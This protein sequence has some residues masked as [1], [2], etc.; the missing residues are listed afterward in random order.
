[1][2]GTGLQSTADNSDRE[3]D[4]ERLATADGVAGPADKDAAKETAGTEQT[5]HGALNGLG[6][7][8]AVARFVGRE[9]KI[10]IPAGLAQSGGHDT[11]GVSI[12]DTAETEGEDKLGKLERSIGC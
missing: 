9:I 10:I 6:V 11:E 1:M 8:I 7:G 12:G 2:R 3:G 4:K 5:V